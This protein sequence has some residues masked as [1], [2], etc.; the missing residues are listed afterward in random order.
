MPD[1]DMAHQVVSA[2]DSIYGAAKVDF[3]NYLSER[4]DRYYAF[5][6]CLL[7]VNLAF[8]RS[9][10]LPSREA[11]SACA[12]ASPSLLFASGSGRTRSRLSSRATEEARC[13]G[14]F[15]TPPIL[16]PPTTTLRSRTNPTRACS[17]PDGA[18]A[19]VRGWGGQDARQNWRR[20]S[21]S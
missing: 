3:D 16:L 15:P 8:H 4:L 12:D 21:R 19:T 11:S 13:R 14:F 7:G 17:A 2:L 18:R 6:Q 9:T 10:W 1:A 20:R 5:L